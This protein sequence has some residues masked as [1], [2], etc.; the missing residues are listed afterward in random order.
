MLFISKIAWLFIFNQITF[1]P[2]NLF[3]AKKIGPC[4]FE[5]HKM[6]QNNNTTRLCVHNSLSIS[7]QNMF[8][9]ILMC[10]STKIFTWPV[11]LIQQSNL[12]CGHLSN[13]ERGSRNEKSWQ[14]SLTPVTAAASLIHLRTWKESRDCFIQKVETILIDVDYSLKK[15]LFSDLSFLCKSSLYAQTVSL[16][17]WFL[18]IKMICIIN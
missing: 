6:D 8:P 9:F 17:A 4:N 16:L 7:S 18:F 13:S 3:F 5:F 15:N 11:S 2:E 14:G 10:L 1:F 12:C